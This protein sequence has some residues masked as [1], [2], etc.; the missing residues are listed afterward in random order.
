MTLAYLDSSALVKLVSAETESGPLAEFI[1]GL[2][3]VPVTSVIAQIEVLR[4]ARRVG[5]SPSSEEERARRMLATLLLVDLDEIV[6]AAGDRDR[7]A[8][9]SFAGRDSPGNSALGAV[10]I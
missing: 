1:E 2:D 8:G 10:A 3:D 7:S 6:V 5:G 9:A 4:A